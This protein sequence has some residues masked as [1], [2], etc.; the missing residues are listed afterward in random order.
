MSNTGI[1][2]QHR[3]YREILI[4]IILLYTSYVFFAAVGICIRVK[5]I[6]E[7]SCYDQLGKICPSGIAVQI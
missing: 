1:I 7:K 6:E 4:V 5:K 2:E 3:H